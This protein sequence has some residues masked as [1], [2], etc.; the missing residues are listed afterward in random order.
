MIRLEQ[1]THLDPEVF[2]V[3]KGY[4]YS[5]T[6]L[7]SYYFLCWLSLGIL[8]LIC[9]WFPKWKVSLIAYPASFE[10][11]AFLLLENNWNQIYI[12]DINTVPFNGTNACFEEELVEPLSFI[13]TFD[14]QYHF[15]IL[16]PKSKLWCNNSSLK[17]FWKIARKDVLNGISK[18]Q[19]ETRQVILGK[20]S[21][22]IKQKPVLNLLMDEGK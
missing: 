19:F 16:N 12:V 20:N 8:Y 18:E 10:T 9:R 4:E 5:R 13:K 15:F 2:I 7:W 22:E 6:K 17:G 14:F 1:K 11:A 21:I 3:I